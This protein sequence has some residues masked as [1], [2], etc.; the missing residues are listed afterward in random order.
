[1]AR[2]C[3]PSAC[4]RAKAASA[5]ASAPIAWPL[6]SSAAIAAPP[7]CPG[8]CTCARRCGPARWPTTS[9]MSRDERAEHNA[10]RS[11]HYKRIVGDGAIYSQPF[12][13]GGAAA[14]GAVAFGTEAKPVDGGFLV[15]GKKIFASLSGAADYYG[16][17]CTE[18]AE[19]DA[20]SRRNTLYL[21][22]AGQCEGR[23]GG[24]RLGPARHA[25]H[26]L[27][28]AALQGRVRAGGRDAD[29]ARRLFPR[30]HL[31]AAHVPHA[32]A[33]L[34]GAGAGGVRFHRRLPARRAARHAARQAAH[35]PD[36]AD[37]GRRDAR[38]AGAD[39][40]AV[41]PGRQRGARQSHRPSRCCAPTPPSSP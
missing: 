36:Q 20:A 10:R 31:L 2:A 14:A 6:P 37:R 16:V 7:R 23:L 27:A 5:P 30:R 34:H 26:R 22:H 3:S 35:V 25:R 15:S 39:Q 12:S 1:M 38:H 21:A 33:H 29:A 28:H 4:P 24:R 9:M 11:V 19:G 40:G 13:E 32:V 17:L 8:T 41:V 18:R